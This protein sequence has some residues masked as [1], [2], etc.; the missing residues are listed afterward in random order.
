MFFGM[1][2]VAFAQAPFP[3]GANSLFAGHSFF[4][5]ISA[6]FNQLATDY[7]Y[8]DHEFNSVFSSGAS[9]APGA[10]WND[11]KDKEA[12]ESVL[13]GGDVELFALT[14]AIGPGGVT[15]GS[16]VDD[17]A[18]WFDLALGYNPDTQFMIGVPW[19]IGGPN[20]GGA[21]EFA[22]ANATAAAAQWETV[23]ALRAAYPEATIHYIDYSLVG[24]ILYEMYEN[25]EI[26]DVTGLTPDPLNGVPA[27]EALFA[28]GLIGHGGPMMVDVA[29]LVWMELLYGADVDS[30]TFT[31]YE[32]DVAAIVN[33]VVAYSQQFAVPVPEPA[34]L[35]LLGAGVLAVLRRRR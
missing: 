14:T 32:T 2:S 12:V 31:E 7:G 34:S 19:V 11:Q 16:D 35:A 9:G 28:D 10:L 21:A 23:Q 15:V 3:T 8:V 29:A 33:E 25:G 20:I 6:K 1:P 24:S 18:R 17:Y 30:L 27:S 4:V 13:M 22:A 5:P 26:P